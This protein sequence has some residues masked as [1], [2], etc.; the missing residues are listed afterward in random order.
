[1]ELIFQED[2]LLI[3][4]LSAPEEMDAAYRLRHE[5]F[6]DELK[7]VPPSPDKRE[8][9]AYDKFAI[10]IGLFDLSAQ[11]GEDLPLIGYVRL[12]QSNYPFMVEKEFACLLPKDKPFKKLPYMVECTRI[13][14]KKERR[15]DKVGDLDLTTGHLLYKAVYN[16]CLTH[17]SRFLI[18]VIEKRYYRHLKSLFPFESLGGFLRMGDGVLAGTVLLDW[19]DFERVSLERRPDFMEWMTTIQVPLPVHAHAPSGLLLHGSY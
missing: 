18:A 16:W 6:V 12:I 14:V 9:D 11:T 15:A 17:N 7:W 3:K 13:C 2:N 4:T 19:R 1:M 5:V 8:T 10:P